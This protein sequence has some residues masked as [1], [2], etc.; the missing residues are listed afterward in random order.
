MLTDS[1]KRLR[2]AR[3]LSQYDISK[4]LGVSQPTVAGWE[5]G[6][7]EPSNDMLRRLARYFGVTTDYLLGNE[8]AG[9][10]GSDKRF[11]EAEADIL[12]GYRELD[13]EGRRTL[14]NVLN[15]LRT[16]N[17]GVG[18][19]TTR[20]TVVNQPNGGVSNL[21]NINSNRGVVRAG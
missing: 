12:M 7:T 16:V 17:Q 21:L 19:H 18:A 20:R 5:R 8:T 3:G 1:I 15:A 4:S 10:N 11:T 13:E 9:A 2:A 14:V 6:R